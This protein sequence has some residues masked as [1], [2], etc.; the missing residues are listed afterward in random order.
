MCP[1]HDNRRGTLRGFDDELDAGLTS[2]SI[3]VVRNNRDFLLLL[4]RLFSSTER[5]N[6]GQYH[7]L[8]PDR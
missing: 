2:Y 1:P 6:T 7:E 3:T 5:P 8:G 4:R